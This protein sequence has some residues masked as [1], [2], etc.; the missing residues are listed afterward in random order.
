[1]YFVYILH[2]IKDNG[3]Y[4]GCTSDIDKRIQYHNSGKTK[5]LKNRRPLVLV[6]VEHYDNATDAYRR[7]KQIKLYKGGEAFKKLLS[8]GGFA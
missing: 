1:M 3:F 6:Y 8:H 7:E 2:S 4:I 5:S